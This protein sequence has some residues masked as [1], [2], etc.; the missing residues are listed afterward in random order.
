MK[1]T[2]QK[3]EPDKNGHRALRL[4]YYHGSKTGRNG[5]RAQK[6]SYE[7]LNLFLYDKPRLPAEREHNKTVNQKAEAI[8]AKRL[9]ESESSRHGLD[10]RTKLSA[11]FFDYF[12]QLTDEKASGSKSNHS[13]WISTR[14]HLHRYHGL[15]ELTFEQVDKRFLEGF[16][17]Y[18]QHEATTKSGTKL[19]KNTTSSYFNKVR[20]ALNQAYRDGIVRDNPVQQVKSI[21]PENTKRTYLTL[22][23]VRALTKAECRYEVL[24]R[25]FLFSC[26]TGLRWSDIHKLVWGEIEEFADGHYR[27]IF[28][29]KKLVNAGNSLQYLD[30]PDSAVRLLNLENRGKPGDRVFKGLKYDSYTNVALAQWVM[31]AG[32][33]KNVTFHAGRHTFAVNQLARGVDIYSLSRLLGHSELRT[34]EIYADILETRRTEAMRSFPDIFEETL[35]EVGECAA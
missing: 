35:D 22:E 9:L 25:A 21:K 16:R 13:I 4:V 30:L 15:S 14:H 27:I 31:R 33:T 8:R 12:D 5:S 1:I 28:R 34:T 7:P 32:I 6:R 19:A 26:T 17:H 24:R 23:E 2:I 20:A 11:S 3:R 10:D 18:L 29:Q